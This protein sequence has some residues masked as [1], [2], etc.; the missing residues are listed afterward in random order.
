MHGW[1]NK[2]N[3]DFGAIYLF[4]GLLIGFFLGSAV[5]YLQFNRQN[6]RIIKEV[7]EKIIAIFSD[8]PSDAR[9]FKASEEKN[10]ES[11]T[12]KTKPAELISEDL[13]ASIRNIKKDDLY[14]DNEIFDESQENILSFENDQSIIPRFN[15]RQTYSLARDKLIHSR[16]VSV[17][18]PRKSKSESGRIL[19][20]V[21]GNFNINSNEQVFHVEFWESPLNSVGY[22][23]S[24]TRVVFYGIKIYEL[25]DIYHHQGKFYLRYM[26]DFYPLEFTNTFKPLIP[27]STPVPF[28]EIQEI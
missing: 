12:E 26:N 4:L 27:Q 23:M 11:P 15:E 10:E 2:K 20:S 6:D 16:M 1:K 8:N 22:K 17:S 9:L 21:I 5:V 7:T 24:K 3:N 14:A 13:S 28:D 18:V 25:A 19:D